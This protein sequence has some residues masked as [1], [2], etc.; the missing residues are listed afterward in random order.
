MK[1]CDFYREPKAVLLNS[2]PVILSELGAR[3]CYDSY[4]KLNIDFVKDNIDFYKNMFSEDENIQEYLKDMEQLDQLKPYFIRKLLKKHPKQLIDNC[5]PNIDFIRKIGIHDGHESVLEHTTLTFDLEFQRNVLQ[6]ISRHRIGVSPSVKSTRYTITALKKKYQEYK[7]TKNIYLFEDYIYINS[8][9]ND[10]GL[11]QKTAEYVVNAMEILENHQQNL[12]N[13]VV[14]N[15][16]PEHWWTSG[17]YTMNV[18]SLKNMFDLR[19]SNGVFFPFRKL[20]YNM[21]QTLPE[22]IR[23][24]FK[25]DYDDDFRDIEDYWNNKEI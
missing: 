16:L 1:I 2:A 4:N 7:S 21:W 19:V 25:D 8:G 13:D 15:I 12:T 9:I 10:S 3:K 5:I 14:K 22:D 11:I 6:E 23:G 17:Q 20:C 24:I 18:R